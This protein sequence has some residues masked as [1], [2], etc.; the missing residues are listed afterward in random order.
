MAVDV[1]LDPDEYV[2]TS[3]G[4]LALEPSQLVINFLPQALP[5][6]FKMI[7]RLLP[8]CQPAWL[9]ISWTTGAI[10]SRRYQVF[11]DQDTFELWFTFWR[12]NVL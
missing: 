11:A 10:S 7:D 5:V 12:V 2:I 1:A 3:T 8:L 6:P 4:A 9:T